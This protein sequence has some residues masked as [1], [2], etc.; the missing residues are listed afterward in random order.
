M[1]QIPTK[2]RQ[3]YIKRNSTKLYFYE[4]V[5][6]SKDSNII[7][8]GDL[9]SSLASLCQILNKL[10][11]KNYFKNNDTFKLYEKNYIIFLGDLVDRGSHS[12]EILGIVFALKKNNEN[13]VFIINGNHEDQRVYNNYGLTNENMTE[14]GKP[15]RLMLDYIKKTR[16]QTPSPLPLARSFKLLDSNKFISVLNNTYLISL[17][18]LIII[19]IIIYLGLVLF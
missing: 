18:F 12:I 3:S 8:I 14:Y 2:Y 19:M 5:I 13:N 15:D 11:S 9:H 4:K 1:A 6:V 10:K 16:N 17:N 7:I